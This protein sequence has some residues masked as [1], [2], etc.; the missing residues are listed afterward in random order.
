MFGS[1]RVLDVRSLCAKAQS[2]RLFWVLRLSGQCGQRDAVRVHDDVGRV[3]PAAS[4]QDRSEAPTPARRVLNSARHCAIN[5]RSTGMASE[6]CGKTVTATTTSGRPARST[7][8]SRPLRARTESSASCQASGTTYPRGPAR[9]QVME[10]ARDNIEDKLG[11]LRRLERKSYAGRAPSSAFRAAR[12]AHEGC[13]DS[14]PVKRSRLSPTS[15][16][17]GHCTRRAR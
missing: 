4:R 15:N 11:E 17:R 16:S 5:T 9:L 13:F 7:A 6:P 10:S 2:L 8:Y 3:C 12:R 14:V 1:G